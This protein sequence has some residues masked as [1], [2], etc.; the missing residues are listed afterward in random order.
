MQSPSRQAGDRGDPSGSTTGRVA[1]GLGWFSLGLGLAELVA[2]GKLGRALGLGGK[3]ALLRFYG[4]REIGAGLG[5]LSAAPAPAIWARF[6][7]D[8]VDLATIAAGLREADET[9]R[10]NAF[11]ALAAVGGITLVDLVTALS[12][13]AE[14]D[15][16]RATAERADARPTRSDPARDRGETTAAGAETRPQAAALQPA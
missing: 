13:S 7:G 6:A 5:A 15:G 8:L 10:R 1:R 4:A 12:L 14:R 2:P 16:E 11:I 9:Q 3:E